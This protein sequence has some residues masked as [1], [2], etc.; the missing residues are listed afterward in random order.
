M[1]T[2]SV[3]QALAVV[4]LSLGLLLPRPAAA[5][6]EAGEGSGADA[7]RV[8][9][10]QGRQLVKQGRYDRACPN[11]ERALQ[12]Y[13]SAGILVNL[14]DCYEKLGR[15]ASAWTAFGQA[16]DVAVRTH[17]PDHVAEAK[18]RQST[19]EPELMRVEIRV[20]SG[21][22]GL[23]LWRDGV[24]VPPA[25][26]GSAVAVDPGTHTVRAEVQGR[27]PWTTSIVARE[28]GQTITVDVPGL[29]AQPPAAAGSPPSPTSAPAP[30]SPDSS[31]GR[32]SRAVLGWAVGG[33]GA[34]VALAGVTLMA[35]ESTRSWSA[36]HSGDASAW[37]STV[38]PWRIGLAGVIVGGAATAVGVVLLLL[39]SS[40]GPAVAVAVQPWVGGAGGVS[41]RGAW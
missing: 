21:A 18:Y 2:C 25:L 31:S 32:S 9:F 14:G 29:F 8:F 13:E 12:L 3:A 19:L 39:P 11:F 17:R 30:A 33:S 36:N 34:A 6:S 27:P 10:E 16:A 23:V 41:L 15:T 7:A 20:P 4:T 38:T 22:V 37:E 26:W 5:Q 40:R 1:T 28:P 24:S 35:V